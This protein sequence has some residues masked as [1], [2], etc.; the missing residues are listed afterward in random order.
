MLEGISI[1]ESYLWLFDT[2]TGARTELT[3]RPAADAEKVAYSRALFA[4]DGKGIFVTTDRDSEF[5]RLAYIDLASKQ[6]TYL[7]PDAKWDVDDWDL[8]SGGQRIA[9]TLNENGTSTL[10]IISVALRD[11]KMTATPEPAPAFEP[12]LAASIISGLKWERGHERNPPR[13]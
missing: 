9:F 7:L 13:L 12:P 4:R 5:L 10:H 6:H 3:P 11:G 1:N 8:D 2:R